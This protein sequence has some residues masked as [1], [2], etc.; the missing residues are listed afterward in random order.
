MWGLGGRNYGTG[1]RQAYDDCCEPGALDLLG[2]YKLEVG[3]VRVQGLRVWR[4]GHYR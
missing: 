3:D 1:F 4:L 2:N